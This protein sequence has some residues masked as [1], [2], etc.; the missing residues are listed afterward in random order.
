MNLRSTKLA[1][2]RG[3]FNKDKEGKTILLSEYWRSSGCPS[4]GVPLYYKEILLS[5]NKTVPLP[6][7]S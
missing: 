3:Y 4:R 7:G 1:Y 6:Q 2:K 5:F